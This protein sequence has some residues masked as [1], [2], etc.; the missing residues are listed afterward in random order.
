MSGDSARLAFSRGPALVIGRTYASFQYYQRAKHHNIVGF[1]DFRPSLMKPGS[2]ELWLR[3]L[4]QRISDC[5][6]TRCFFF[7]ESLSIADTNTIL[8][9]LV[10]LK[11]VQIELIPSTGL[12][13]KSVKP[14]LVFSALSPGA[15]KSQLAS[16]FCRDL[17]GAGRSVAVI[18]SLSQCDW[19][20]R[21]RKP[22]LHWELG[23]RDAVPVHPPIAPDIRGLIDLYQ[24]SRAARVYVT[25]NVQRALIQAE[26]KADIIVYDSR[27]CEDAWVDASSKFCV[28]DYPSLKKPLTYS[29]WPGLTNIS[30]SDNIVVIV[31]EKKRSKLTPSGDAELQALFPD[32]A[33][34]YFND[35]DLFGHLDRWLSHYHLARQTP[36][37]LKHFD[38]QVEI[39]A[40]MSV[41]SDTELHVQN[42][43]SANREA[44]CRLFLSSHLPPGYHVTT[45]EIIDSAGNASGQLDVVIVTNY[46]PRMTIDA[47]HSLIAPI[48]AEN[49]LGV[50][51]VKTS[52]SIDSLQKALSQVRP[53]KSLMPGH[54]RLTRSDGKTVADPLGGKIVTGIFSFHLVDG[55]EQQIPSILSRHPG[56]VDFV[57]VPGATAWFSTAAL[58]VCGLEGDAIKESARGFV[59][60]GEP[61]KGL[62]FIFGILNVLAAT[63][64][65]GGSTCVRYV[66]GKWR[67]TAQPSEVPAMLD[68]VRRRL[69]GLKSKKRARKETSDEDLARV[70][71]QLKD[72]LELLSSMM[73]PKKAARSLEV[74][75]RSKKP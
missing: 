32:K 71:G 21:E 60:F 35:G 39:I 40:A 70:E 53:V 44:F 13:M 68:E 9:C 61:G 38:A 62:G 63:R 75:E 23:P 41:A 47:T 34:F 54:S 73:E 56:V 72:L 7:V 12:E 69:P 37:L 19:L 29:Q 52:L 33:F 50:V 28:V 65:F 66:D 36:A 22:G 26:Q 49:V 14:L 6:V 25:F 2:F 45:G 74:L 10:S 15:A 57:V 4:K 3:E 8:Y 55:V 59:R 17:Q 30:N 27:D 18:V 1:M 24:R 11:S 46:S 20:S 16:Y 48:V 31:P 67:A 58:R 42:N 43:D 64:R 5:G 51:E